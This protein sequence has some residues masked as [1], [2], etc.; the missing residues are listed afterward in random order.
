MSSFKR[1][2]LLEELQELREEKNKLEKQ[3]FSLKLSAKGIKPT[4]EE[5][6]EEVELRKQ[7]DWCDY[8][9]GLIKDDIHIA[10]AARIGVSLL[11]ITGLAILLLTTKGCAKKEDSKVEPTNEIIYEYNEEEMP[12]NKVLKI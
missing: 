8:R 5:L 1:I 6:E 7:I 4:Y 10:V 2:S 11:G 9:M 12:I 3:L